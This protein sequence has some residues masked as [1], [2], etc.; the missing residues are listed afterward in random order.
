MYNY[1]GQP[2]C[3]AKGSFRSQIFQFYYDE[4]KNN[5]FWLSSS[6]SS[7]QFLIRVYPRK[8]GWP[9]LPHFVS[10]LSNSH[11]PSRL[12]HGVLFLQ[13]NALALLLHLRLTRLLWSSSLP[14]ALH[15]KLQ[16]FSQNMTHHPSSTHART[17]SATNCIHP[18]PQIMET[19]HR[20][21]LF[22][23]PVPLIHQL[24]SCIF[25]TQN[26]SPTSRSPSL[27][28]HIFHGSISHISHTTLNLPLFAS[29]KYHMDLPYSQTIHLLPHCVRFN[30]N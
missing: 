18:I 15:F 5:S 14:L 4:I 22:T 11:S 23:P 6:S 26:L 29:H 13:T 24:A 3:P 7:I 25:H 27:L 16:R 28:S 2:L 1:C 8:R 17:I 20:F 9:D 12:I 30:G 21:H 10:N 19:S